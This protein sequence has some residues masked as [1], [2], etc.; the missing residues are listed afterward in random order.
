MDISFTLG[1]HLGKVTH[2][3]QA[4]TRLLDLLHA[5]LHVVVQRV[6]DRLCLSGGNDTSTVG[7]HHEM[8]QFL[9]NLFA[10]ADL[11]HFAQQSLVQMLL[12]ADRQ[13]HGFV[14]C[15]LGLHKAPGHLHLVHLLLDAEKLQQLLLTLH[16]GVHKARENADL[17]HVLTDLQCFLIAGQPCLDQ[18]PVADKSQKPN[19]PQH[20]EDACNTNYSPICG[21]IFQTALLHARSLCLV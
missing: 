11:I 5:L 10:L 14:D 20:T 6:K 16:V 18:A 15:T 9:C 7:I 3:P 8:L 4:M 21:D 13:G 12:L 1:N 2:F 19:Q 17:L